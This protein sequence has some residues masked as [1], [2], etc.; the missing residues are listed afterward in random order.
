[1]IDIQLKQN[2]HLQKILSGEKSDFTIQTRS[3]VEKVRLL[4][5]RDL[6]RLGWEMTF[7]SNRVLIKPPDAYDKQIVKD[8]MQ[9]KRQES[10]AKNA[11]WIDKHHALMRQNLADG[12]LVWNSK[13]EPSI[14]VCETQNQIDIFRIFRFYWSSPYSELSGPLCQDNKESSLRW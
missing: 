9:I 5:V 2:T 6:L 3:P 14:E 7:K 4:I 1:M 11:K 12:G 10:L 8:S 13:I